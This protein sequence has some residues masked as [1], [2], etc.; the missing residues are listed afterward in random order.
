MEYM[1]NSYSVSL[2]EIRVQNQRHVPQAF[3]P[4]PQVNP[5]KTAG[6]WQNCVVRTAGL[7]RNQPK[8]LENLH[9]SCVQS[10]FV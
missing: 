9:F 10:G 1:S 7:E 8:P 4:H 3:S 2:A 6:D 5:P